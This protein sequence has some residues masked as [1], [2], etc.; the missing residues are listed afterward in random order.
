[1]SIPGIRPEK[2]VALLDEGF[3]EDYLREIMQV[4]PCPKNPK[5]DLNSEARQMLGLDSEHNRAAVSMTN[6][7]VSV[8]APRRDI[9]PIGKRYE[10]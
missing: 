6:W 4:K 7:D 8:T 10:K 1:M 2:L 9:N 5:F 3:S